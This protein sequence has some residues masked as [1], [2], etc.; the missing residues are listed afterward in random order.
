[1]IDKL[2]PYKIN[3]VGK[4]NPHVYVCD[5]CDYD[6]LDDQDDDVLYKLTSHIKGVSESNIGV[7]FIVEC[8][9]CFEPW[10]FHARE[11][12][13]YGGY[14]DM[15]LESIECGENLHIKRRN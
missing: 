4:Y 12:S 10:Y 11:K 5:N 3:L 7:V 2:K 6:L 9:N 15:F 1:M 13:K 14:A 8:P